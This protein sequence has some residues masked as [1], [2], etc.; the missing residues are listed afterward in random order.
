MTP[1]DLVSSGEGMRMMTPTATAYQD[2]ALRE[3]G[4]IGEVGKRP[5]IRD[6]KSAISDLRSGVRNQ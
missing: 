5:E 3:R 6:Q 4:G 2:H 1:G